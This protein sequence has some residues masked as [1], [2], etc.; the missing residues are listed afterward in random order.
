VSTFSAKLVNVIFMLGLG[1]LTFIIGRKYFTGLVGLIAGTVVLFN[2]VLLQ[3][4]FEPWNDLGLAFLILSFFYLFS[5][6]RR[7]GSLTARRG[8]IGG[9]V[10][11]LIYLQKPVGVLVFPSVV[12]AILLT[13]PKRFRAHLS[14]LLSIAL[15][16]L[17][18]AS[19]YFI[20]NWKLFGSPTYTTSYY[21][22]FITKYRDFQ[23]TFRIYYND[24]PSFKTLAG[25]GW[26]FVFSK[27]LANFRFA[28]AAILGGS[29]TS[30]FVH[31]TSYLGILYWLS[32]RRND[33][34]VRS[35][36]IFLPAFFIF[37]ILWWH[38]QAYYF[39]AFI[40]FLCLASAVAFDKL[41]RGVSPTLLPLV[42]AVFLF[43]S[44]YDGI[45]L[46]VN[47]SHGGMHES[48]L[49]SSAWI[50]NNTPQDSVVMTMDPWELNFHTRRKAVLIPLADY[51]AIL[52]IMERYDVDYLQ[53]GKDSTWGR[54]E[55]SDL[56]LGKSDDK[57]F[58]KVYEDDDSLMYKIDL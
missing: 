2:P 23:E 30:P 3:L 1:F 45:K 13:S 39:A 21:D 17:L 41:T 38:Y 51:D 12:L 10:L 50:V 28:L 9:V 22:A 44:S 43:F 24:L 16:S 31:G 29:L 6:S 7:S 4:S 33:F 18:V 26:G 53:L 49:I 27:I 32:K 40:P 19:P 34:F 15:I 47:S 52:G 48:R 55:L 37:F 54:D 57:R 42:L 14:G 46:L 25:Y 11:G 20:R 58:E 35:Y 56:M 36:A 5:E 8:I